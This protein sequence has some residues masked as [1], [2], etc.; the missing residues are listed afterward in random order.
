MRSFICIKGIMR[1]V[2]NLKDLPSN[3]LDLGCS[4]TIISLKGIMVLFWLFLKVS[5][6]FMVL[7]FKVGFIGIKKEKRIEI[8]AFLKRLGCSYTKI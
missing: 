4:A 1:R 6:I 7:C 5:R 8:R 2:G 3:F